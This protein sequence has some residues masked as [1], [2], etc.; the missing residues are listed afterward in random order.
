MSA[1]ESAMAQPPTRRSRRKRLL[2]LLLLLA[3]LFLTVCLWGYYLTTRDPIT[4]VLP[5]ARV[6][7]QAIAPHYLFSIYGVQQPIGVAVTPDGERIYVTESDGERMI[8]A[9]DRDGK[10]LFAFAPPDSN[11]PTRAPVYVTLD[12]SGQV[13]VTDRTRHAVDVYDAGGN[14]KR[15][16]KE[17]TSDGWSPLG[18]RFV[19]QTLYLTDVTDKK[20]RVLV[21]D[22]KG[23]LVLNFGRE[24]QKP[25]ELWFPNSALVDQRNR[26]LV[27]DSNNGRVQVFDKSGKL[28]NTLAGF[29]LPRGLALDE[30]QRLYVVDTVG[31][32]VKVFDASQEKIEVLF[33]FGEYG[34]R[35]GEFNYPNDIAVDGTGR[36]YITDRVS[37]RVQVWLY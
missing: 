33:T 28:V 25:D 21:Q 20:H 22:T 14:Y 7:A 27:S 16:L 11:P 15:S 24:G 30:D 26:I 13:Y 2:L 37:N 17:L 32:L 34:V 35:D 29:S 31:Q 5:P 36:L 23:K 6:V 9:F 10:P 12:R 1:S 4:K 8:R 19:D 18:L 3:L